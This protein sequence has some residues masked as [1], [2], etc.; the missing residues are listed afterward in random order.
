LFIGTK[1]GNTLFYAPIHLKKTHF[2]KEKID[3]TKL[4]PFVSTGEAIFDLPK[5]EADSWELYLPMIYS[6]EKTSRHIWGR[7]I[8]NEMNA[9]FIQELTWHISRPHSDRDL[10]DFKR[11]REG[12]NSKHALARG[13]KLETPY[14]MESF[15]D[16]YKRQDGEDLCSTIVAHLQKDGL[17]FI[18]PRQNRS[19]TPR[20]A[21]RIQSFQIISSF[22]D[23]EGMFIIKLEMLY[24]RLLEEQLA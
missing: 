22:P 3:G 19:L 16:K 12:E 23:N 6:L 17:M 13:V 14:S 9:A 15:A 8:I 2:Y 20:E 24:P 7:Y 18:H 5:L 1:V 11:L 4:Q 21:A 10:R